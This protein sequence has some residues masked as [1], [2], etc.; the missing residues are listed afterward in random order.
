[1]IGRSN[2]HTHGGRSYSRNAPEERVLECGRASGACMMRISA[3]AATMHAR[4]PHA[5]PHAAPLGAGPS[6]LARVQGT[7]L[8]VRLC[9][10]RAGAWAL[11]TTHR[12]CPR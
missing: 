2:T 10:V 3:R 11:C 9:Q 12:A 1:M 4:V 8:H 5:A 6:L 7:A